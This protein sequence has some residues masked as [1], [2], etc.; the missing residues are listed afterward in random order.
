MWLLLQL[1]VGGQLDQWSVHKRAN[2]WRQSLPTGFTHVNMLAGNFSGPRTSSVGEFT[3]LFVSVPVPYNFSEY[4]AFLGNHV[5]EVQLTAKCHLNFKEP[6][7]GNIQGYF[8][9]IR[10]GEDFS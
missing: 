3:D 1:V 7:K 9:P 10:V 6:S 5:R 8:S 4:L 2:M